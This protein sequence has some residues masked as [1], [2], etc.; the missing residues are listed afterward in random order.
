MSHQFSGFF[1]PKLKKMETEKFVFNAVAFDP[2]KIWTCLA[3]QNGRQHLSFLKDIYNVGKKLPE[4]VV[5][6]PNSKVVSFESKQ[7]INDIN[8]HLF[9]H[10]VRY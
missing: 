8:T 4:M 1:L 6:W 10:S 3:P 7:S 9:S 5:K 2:I